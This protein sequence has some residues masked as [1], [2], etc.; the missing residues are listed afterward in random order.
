MADRIDSTKVSIV[1]QILTCQV[2]LI[3]G[4][5]YCGSDCKNQGNWNHP[6]WHFIPQRR[7]KGALLLIVES[8]QSFPFPLPGETQVRHAE[9]ICF[10]SNKA[11]RIEAEGPLTATAKLGRYASSKLIL[12]TLLDK[13]PP[14]QHERTAIPKRSSH[15]NR[16]SE[17]K[18][19]KG[20]MS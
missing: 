8:S 9:T 18:K 11:P 1:E 4:S 6:K 19:M 14:L 13:M 2:T 5:A 3:L 20:N 15:P 16:H 10:E 17:Q 7:A 12:D